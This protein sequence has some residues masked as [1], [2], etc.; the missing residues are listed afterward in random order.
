MFTTATGR[1]PGDIGKTRP[2]TSEVRTTQQNGQDGQDS[3]T[4]QSQS[5]DESRMTKIARRAHEIYQARGGEHGKALDDWLQ[6]ER[7]VD[8]EIEALQA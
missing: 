8:A 7:E 4:A 6:A 1:K 5:N 3:P 2:S